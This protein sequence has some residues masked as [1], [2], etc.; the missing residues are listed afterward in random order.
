MFGAA[1]SRCSAGERAAKPKHFVA[2]PL[3]FALTSLARF[4]A[5]AGNGPQ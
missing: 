4:I 3:G 1:S 2:N 5:V